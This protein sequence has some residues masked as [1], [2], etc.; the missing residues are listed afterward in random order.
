MHLQISRR[1]V[2]TNNTN[3]KQS[4]RHPYKGWLQPLIHWMHDTLSKGCVPGQVFVMLSPKM[5]SA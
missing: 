5:F 4:Q 3:A 2:S 1:E